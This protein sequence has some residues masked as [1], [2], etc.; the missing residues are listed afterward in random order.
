M[1]KNKKIIAI[2]CKDKGSLKQKKGVLYLRV[3]I[4]S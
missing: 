2:S 3:R 4:T 1:L